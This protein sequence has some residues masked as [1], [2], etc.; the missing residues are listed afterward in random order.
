MVVT[1]YITVHGFR[2][3]RFR[4]DELAIFYMFSL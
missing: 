2:V 4:V 3:Q 1:L